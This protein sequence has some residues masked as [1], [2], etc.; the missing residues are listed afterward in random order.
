MSVVSKEVAEKEVNAFLDSMD[1]PVENR[2]K[3]AVKPM[4]DIIVGAVMSGHLV[5][6]TDGTLTQKLKEKLGAG[7]IT[8]IV[9]D[10]RFEIGELGKAMKGVSMVDEVEFTV[11]RL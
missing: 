11:A 10:F 5:F 9:Y 3:D 2:T 1:I 6:N 4:I 7:D 8:E